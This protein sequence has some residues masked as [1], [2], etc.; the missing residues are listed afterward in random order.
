MTARLN[1]YDTS[2]E[3]NV[4]A[5]MLATQIQKLTIMKKIMAYCLLSVV[6]LSCTTLDKIRPTEA[7]I[8]NVIMIIGEKTV[9]KMEVN[10][11]FFVYQKDNRENLLAQ[12]E[13]KLIMC[14][15]FIN[16]S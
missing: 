9:T 15:V 6:L 1:F 12:A 5:T 11:A 16:L 10:G 8:K 13:T 3:V 14:S 4:W 2:G 7:K